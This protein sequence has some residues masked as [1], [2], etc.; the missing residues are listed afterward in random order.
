[1]RMFWKKATKS[2]QRWAPPPRHPALLFPL[3]DI[4][5]SSA[6]LVSNSA[7]FVGGGAKTFFAPGR[8][9]S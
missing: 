9:V 6:F 3:T 2:P 7:V 4:H 8:R 5:L 1:M